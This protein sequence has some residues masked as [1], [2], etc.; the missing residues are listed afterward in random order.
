MYS[1]VTCHI[2]P[3]QRAGLLARLEA[4]W[5]V[6]IRDLGDCSGKERAEVA[7]HSGDWLLVPGSASR[8]VFPV[9]NTKGVAIELIP[10]DV[11]MVQARLDRDRLRLLNGQAPSV[12]LLEVIP[13]GWSDT[14]ATQVRHWYAIKLFR[15]EKRDEDSGEIVQA[16]Y[17]FGVAY[18]HLPAQCRGL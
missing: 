9:P 18:E 11:E 14:P 1:A 16:F 15:G 6:P 4:F 8:P 17:L 13:S 10:R 2:F 7:N 12:L 3:Q 5:Q